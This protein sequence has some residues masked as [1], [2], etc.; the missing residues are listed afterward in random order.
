MSN[1]NKKLFKR[2]HLNHAYGQLIALIFV[3]IMVLACVGALLVLSETSNASR[4]QQ[5]QMAIAIMTRYQLT[6]EAALDLLDRYPWQYDQARNAMQSMLNEKHLVRAAII[7]QKGRTRLSIGFQDQ[8]SWPAIED[9][10]A[11]TGPITYHQNN[12]YALRINE[13]SQ[14]PAR[15]IIELDNQPLQIAHYRVMIVLITTGLLTL[16][17]LL[18]CLNFYSRRWIAPMYEIRMQLQRLSADT[19]DQHM[20]INSTGELRLLQRDIANVVKRLHFSF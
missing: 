6:S 9:K 16:L 15:L 19:L 1:I 4:A 7:D 10:N 18:L 11:F 3:P 14:S 2:L 5:K 8:E 20:V 12:I 13:N 17:L